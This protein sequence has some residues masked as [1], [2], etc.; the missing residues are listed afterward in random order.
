M[1]SLGEGQPLIKCHVFKIIKM[2][3]GIVVYKVYMFNLGPGWGG[4]RLSLILLIPTIGHFFQIQFLKRL[5]YLFLALFFYVSFSI[6]IP[7]RNIL[8]IVSLKYDPPLF[9]S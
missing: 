8:A 9:F 7:S 3:L 1:S 2:P 6:F 4:G 5:L